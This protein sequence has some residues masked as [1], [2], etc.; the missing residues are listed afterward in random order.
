MVSIP[1]NTSAHLALFAVAV[2]Y[3]LNYFISKVVFE[4][5]SPFGVLAM[6]SLSALTF[7]GILAVLFYREKLEK[8]DLLRVLFCAFSGITFNQLFFLWGLA[9]TT[10]INAAVLMIT[11]PIFV[12]L[13]AYFGRT[14][15]ITLRKILGIILAFIGSALLITT[16]KTVAIGGETLR[17]DLMIII[18]ALSYAV[19]LVA[20]KP[21]VA[22]YSPVFLFAILFAIGGSINIAIGIQD[23][24]AANWAL[25]PT[26][27]IWYAV[28][29]MICTTILAYL[30]NLW[31][32]KSV[33]ASH[34]SIYV[35]LQPVIAGL[36]TAAQPQKAGYLTFSKIACIL[37]VFVGV[38][39][40]TIQK[41][42]TL[43][44]LI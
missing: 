19:Y 35:Y 1:K 28:Y 5:V 8:K 39:L 7:F 31:A 4:Y 44:K 3:G 11:A 20:V 43:E 23:L 12:F 6:R 2:I 18:N 40:V 42:K 41:R 17:G 37:L 10:E 15:T 30:L 25:F 38:G 26:T 36:L 9:E 29:I 14:E 24:F 21:L 32:M 27:V 16:G 22:K 13:I 33:P 34:V